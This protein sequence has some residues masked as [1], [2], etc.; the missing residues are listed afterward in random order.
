MTINPL[1]YLKRTDKW[2][3]SGGK[4]L[5]WAPTHPKFLQTLGFWDKAH[6]LSYPINHLFSIALLTENCKLINPHIVKRIWYPN[7]LVT[8]YNSDS[9]Q[10]RERKYL[11][12]RD[13]LVSDLSIENIS[14]KIQSVKL[15]AW[16]WQILKDIN[17]VKYDSQENMLTM[18]L[19]LRKRDYKLSVK[20]LL[21]LKGHQNT[22]YLML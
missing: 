12:F 20:I 14:P 4:G 18:N 7:E 15:V 6:F 2:Y 3:V 5:T 11:N 1:S 21:E 9:L 17:A 22:Q 16:G 19:L 10:I 13:V 8:E